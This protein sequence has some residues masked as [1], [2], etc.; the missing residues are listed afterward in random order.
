MR[1]ARAI[2]SLALASLA[3]G[4]GF[5]PLYGDT[6]TT[7]ETA[8]K[9]AAIYV[10][11]I[12]DN[13]LGYE[14]R[15]ELIDLFDA[16]GDPSKNIYRL[17]VTLNTKSEGVAIQNDAAIT[18]YNDTLTVS[19]SLTDAKG[20]VITKG[21]ET[22]LSAY[23][24]VASPYAT[25]TAQQSADKNTAVDIAYRIRTDLAVYFAQTAGPRPRPSKK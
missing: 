14:L 21:I 9:L 20:Q 24:V 10:D 19:Y 6:G 16:S 4:C 15:N 3:G 1:H 2:L 22:G 5:H 18:R 12:P 25:L 11:P 13:K 23:N 8:G 17:R 7:A